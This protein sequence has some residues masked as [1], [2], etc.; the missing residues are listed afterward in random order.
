MVGRIADKELKCIFVKRGEKAGVSQQIKDR[1][2]D[3][4]RQSR[5]AHHMCLFPEATTTNGRY[6]L[7]FK[8]GAFVPGAPVKPVVLVYTWGQGQ[9]SP[10]WDCLQA[11]LHIFLLLCSWGYKITLLELPTYY[12]SEEVR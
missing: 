7:P 8:T 5:A 12:P 3:A 2:A 10:A 11:P 9:M 6:L 4:A 1:V